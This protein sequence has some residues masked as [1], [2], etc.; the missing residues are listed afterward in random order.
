MRDGIQIKRPQMSKGNAYT[1]KQWTDLEA[2]AVSKEG[3][4]TLRVVKGSM[5]DAPP[6]SPNSEV[7]AVEHVP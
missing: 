1:V 2:R 6:R 7:A 5:A 3:F 4:G